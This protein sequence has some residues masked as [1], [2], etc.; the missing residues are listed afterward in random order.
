SG[1]YSFTNLIYGQ[2]YTVTAQALSG[3]TLTYLSSQPNPFSL[4]NLVH[5]RVVNFGYAPIYSISG[6][7]FVDTNKNGLK[8]AGES[9]YIA[10]TQAVTLRKGDGTYIG[11]VN[12][13]ADGTYVFSNLTAGTYLVQYTGP[14]PSGY[15]MTWP[16]NGP[17]NQF[18]V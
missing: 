3:Y 6:N 11:A 12:A 16:V 15:R 1:N 2:N 5:D 9:N 10:T 7:V 8:G 4:P 17:P 18:T 14:V 13:A